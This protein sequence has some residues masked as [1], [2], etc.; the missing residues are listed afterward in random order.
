MKTYYIH[1]NNQTTHT[2]IQDKLTMKWKRVCVD[3]FDKMHVLGNSAKLKVTVQ[4]CMYVTVHSRICQELY[5]AVG[6]DLSLW[7]DPIIYTRYYKKLSICLHPES[8]Q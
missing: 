7:Y 5:K 3:N 2:P 6:V 4:S 8:L 1:Q